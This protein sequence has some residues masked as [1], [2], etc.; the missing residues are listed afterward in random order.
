M[1]LEELRQQASRRLGHVPASASFDLRNVGLAD[2]LALL[3]AHR[4]DQ[5]LL[6]HR[7]AEA[8]QRAFNLPEVTNFLAQLHIANRDIYIAI[9][10][11]W[12]R[13]ECG[14]S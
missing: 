7:A 9:C 2:A 10:N 3:P 5:F 6:G 1:H 14:F 13:T 4:R 12:S 11:G 8:A